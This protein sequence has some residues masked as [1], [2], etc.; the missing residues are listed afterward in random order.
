MTCENFRRVITPAKR[1]VQFCEVS[2]TDM[3]CAGFQEFCFYP[4]KFVE[5][6]KVDEEDPNQIVIWEEDLDW[7]DYGN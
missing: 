3:H 6:D 5:K 7:R 4:D 2:G 1:E